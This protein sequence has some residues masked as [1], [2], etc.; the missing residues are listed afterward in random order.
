M[1]ERS[2]RGRYLH[3]RI[4][5][6]ILLDFREIRVG[7]VVGCG[8]GLLARSWRKVG[9][10][11]ERRYP[12][13]RHPDRRYPD[14]RYPEGVIPTLSEA[15]AELGCNSQSSGFAKAAITGS[16]DQNRP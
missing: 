11:P 9:R 1:A 13:R 10:H 6:V 7:R 14:R 12:D 5:Q 15:S 4:P 8:T 3:R 16:P 2:E